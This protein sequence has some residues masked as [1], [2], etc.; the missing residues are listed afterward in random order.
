M[1]MI[2]KTEWRQNLAASSSNYEDFGQAF[3]DKLAPYKSKKIRV[4]QVPHMTKNL[5]KVIV[6]RSPLKPKYLNTNT[7][8]SL[9]LYKK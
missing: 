9:R 4:N 5:R 3:L 2:L 1:L 7:T 8:E 6:K